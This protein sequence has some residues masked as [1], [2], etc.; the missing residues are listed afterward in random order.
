MHRLRAPGGCPW[1]AEQTHSSLKQYVIEEAYE[2]VEAIDSGS[3]EHMREELG[4]L[5]LQVV[6][7]AELGSERSVFEIRDV[8]DGLC[9]KLVR[10]HPHV[11]ADA[12][13]GS[14]EEVVLNWDRIKAQEKAGKNPEPVSALTGVPRALPAL[15]RA[16]RIGQKAAAAGFDWD[17]AAGVREKLKEEV[18]EL[19]IALANG[20]SGEIAAELGDVL[21]TVVSLARRVGVQAETVL[22]AALDRFENRFRHMERQLQ[23]EGLRPETATRD[24]LDRAWGDAKRRT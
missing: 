22:H 3:D 5:L 17:D 4:D 2:L 21:F 6:F 12:H 7:H 13:V 20:A 11:F 16:H 24:Q 8:I 18:H 9:E 10:R 23:A 19:D 1:D 14:S 15:L